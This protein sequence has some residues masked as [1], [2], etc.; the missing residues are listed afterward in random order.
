MTYCCYIERNDINVLSFFRI[1]GHK[2]EE[3]II[4]EEFRTTIEEILEFCPNLRKLKIPYQSILFKEIKHF[5]PQLQGFGSDDHWLKISAEDVNKMEIG[6]NKYSKTFKTLNVFVCNITY[7][8]MKTCIEYNSRFEN[9]TKLK[10]QIYSVY[11]KTE[12][13]KDDY[14]SPIGQK[15]NKLL[16]L[17]LCMNYPVSLSEQFFDTFTQFKVIK[18]LKIRITDYT[19]KKAS[20]GRLKHCEQLEYLEIY[21]SQIT[22][23]FFTDIQLFLPNL[24]FLKISTENEFSDSFIDSFH[25]MKSIQ[26][27]FIND[28]HWYFGKQLSEVMS[29]SEE[30]YVIRVN[31]NCGLI[32]ITRLDTIYLNYRGFRHRKT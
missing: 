11:A 9:L 18:A 14:L 5:L 26:K 25:S 7:E 30:K 32:N 8:E 28:K 3:L 19:T 20:I 12:Q 31:N 16:K 1:Y 23:D 17:D 27:V 29:S 22:E 13:P 4:S 21:Y 10:L 2:L 24:Q 15:C 6:I